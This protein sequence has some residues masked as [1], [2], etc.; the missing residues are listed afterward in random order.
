MGQI[1][2]RFGTISSSNTNYTLTCMK[3]WGKVAALGMDSS[4]F[5][6]LPDNGD[7]GS[8]FEKF[9]EYESD[10]DETQVSILKIPIMI[11]RR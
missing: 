5:E 3:N 4:D 1:K 10:M 6:N 7:I 8:I 11:I 2:E 9:G